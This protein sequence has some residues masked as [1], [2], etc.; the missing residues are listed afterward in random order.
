MKTDYLLHEQKWMPQSIKDI[1][2]KLQTLLEE[3][4]FSQ[5]LFDHLENKD[6]KHSYTREDIE[7]VVKSVIA[8]P[9]SPFEVRVTEND[10]GVN[11]VT[12]YCVRTKLNAQNDITLVISDTKRIITAW[13]NDKNDKH[14]T[15]DLHRYYSPSTPNEGVTYRK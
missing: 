12:K 9:I 14:Y 1:S 5:H 15:L 10:W 2:K 13:I 11:H 7:R 4:T 6:R 3:K 8:N